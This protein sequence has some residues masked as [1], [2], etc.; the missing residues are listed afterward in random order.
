MTAYVGRKDT[1]IMLQLNINIYPVGSEFMVM[2]KYKFL[3]LLMLFVNPLKDH[4]LS[5]AQTK[6]S[7]QFYKKMITEQ[8]S[9][10]LL[11]N[12]YTFF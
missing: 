6:M 5:E 11:Q 12:S 8:L 1:S 3:H 7:G 4:Q 2:P 10:R 9:K